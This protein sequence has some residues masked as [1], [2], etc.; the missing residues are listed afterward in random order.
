MTYALLE[1]LGRTNNKIGKISYLGSGLTLSELYN[2]IAVQEI[3]TSLDDN[4]GTQDIFPTFR[5]TGNDFYIK[6]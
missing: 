1:A 2:Y 4:Y 3:Y 5:K 6:R